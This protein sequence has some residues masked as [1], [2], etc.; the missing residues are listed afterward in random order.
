MLIDGD[1]FL[2][3][4]VDTASANLAN[5]VRDPNCGDAQQTNEM[6]K[7][8]SKEPQQWEEFFNLQYQEV[9]HLEVPCRCCNWVSWSNV[10]PKMIAQ[11]QK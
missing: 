1:P 11:H 6:K 8:V 9:L 10:T 7:Q 4:A 3:V 2:D 5:L